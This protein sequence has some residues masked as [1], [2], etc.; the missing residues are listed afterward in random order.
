MSSREVGISL[1]FVF[2]DAWKLLE[3]GEALLFCDDKHVGVNALDFFQAKLV[4]GLRIHAGR[5]LLPYGEP[6]ERFSIGQRP[7]ARLG[8]AEGR[9]I[10]GDIVAELDVGGAYF[11]VDGGDNRV[12]QA[13]LVGGRNRRR[14]LRHR[15]AEGA[16]FSGRSVDR[17]DLGDYLVQKE[18]WRH[19]FVLL[20]LVQDFDDLIEGPR[21]L[22]QP[23]EVVLVLFGG[24]EGDQLH[25]LRQLQVC[26]A[27]L[28]FGHQ[29][30]FQRRDFQVLF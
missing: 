12:V 22:V 14:K 28:V 7:E 4:N 11:G 23:G 20:A 16:G 29:V 5:R 30:E 2:R 8:S 15:H 27:E 9:V 21:Y 13:L 25:K 24:V 1:G 17:L 18:L 6:V 3:I 10:L 19:H 26:A